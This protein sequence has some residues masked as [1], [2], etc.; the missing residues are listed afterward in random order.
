MNDVLEKVNLYRTIN[1][2]TLQG[3]VVIFGADFMADF[4]FYEL[5]QKYL[6]SAALY[7]RSL[8][9][10][11]LPLADRYLKECVLDIHPSKV[12]FA[13]G[14]NDLEDPNA[15]ERYRKLIMRTQRALPHTRLY[16]LPVP[17]TT[18]AAKKFN[19]ELLRLATGL[20]LTCPSLC[21]ETEATHPPYSKIFKKL[22]VLFRSGNLD[23]TEV[24]ALAN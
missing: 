6:F 20:G 22:T 23:L 24:F 12:F 17:E 2:I 14:E 8:H 11:T 15:M 4:P 10:L 5:S 18:P 21:Y 1:D 9:G 7:N 3:E 16:L 13:L 19:L